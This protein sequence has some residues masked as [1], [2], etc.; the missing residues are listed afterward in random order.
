MTLALD[1]LTA[2]FSLS[3]L[4]ATKGSASKRLVPDVHHRPIR[5]PEHRLGISAGRVEHV[6][7]AG[8]TGLAALLQRVST[9]QAL[10]HGI[11]IGSAPGEVFKLV[12]AEQF[13]GTPGTIAR[14]KACIQYP[15]GPH[16]L[17]LDRD[18]EPEAA[19]L[20]NAEE[21]MRCM[22]GVLPAFAEVGWLATSSTSSAIREKQSGDWLTPP[23]GWHI[24]L[25]ATGDVARFGDLLKVRL[26]LTG[27]G[28]CKLAT[29][30]TQTGVCAILERALVDLMVFSPERLDYVAG[31]L[32]DKRAPFYQDR[33]A[34][35]LHAG[36]V[37]DLDAFPDV[38]DEERAQYA[39]LVAEAKEPLAPERRAR[40]RT[41]ITTA[42]PTLPETEVEQEITARLTHA[43]RGELAP[44]HTVYFVN[45]VSITAAAL[46]GP[47]GKKLDGKRLADPQEPTYRQGED[48]VFHWRRGDW[49]MVSWAHGIQITYQLAQLAPE[50]PSSDDGDMDDL[51]ARVGDTE[52]LDGLARGAREHDT[53]GLT[54]PYRATPHGLVWEKLTKDGP[55]DVL[56]TNFTATIT[57]DILEDDGAETRHRYALTVQHKGQS[58]GVEILAT[59]LAGMNWV[60][61]HL[62][63]TAI[64]M[65]GMT[66]KDHARAAIQ[67]LSQQITQH[68]VYTH[69]GWRKVGEDWC[70]LHAGGAIGAQGP[71][72]EVTVRPGEALAW[73]H[74]PTPPDGEAAR[75]AIRASFR[76]LDVAEDTVTMPGYAAVWRAVLGH[77][78]FGVHLAGATGQ[79][80]TELAA[81]LQQHW[82]GGM[83]ARRLPAS[84]SSTGNALEGLAFQAKDAMLVVD[85]FCPT[86]AKADI[87]RYHR[88][89]DRLMRAQGNHSG[90]QRMRQD[91]TLRPVKPPRGLIL[92]TGEDIP[93]GQSLRARLL[94][95]DVAPGTV[96]WQTLTACQGAATDGLYAQALAGFVRWLAPRYGE[97]V[98]DVA[99]ELR[100]LRQ[101]VLHDGHRRTPD[102]IANLALGM[103]YVLAYAHDCGAFT[104][105][106]CHT[107]WRRIW[108]ALGDVAAAQQEHQVGEEPASRFLALLAGAIAA[109]HAHVADA[110]TLYAPTQDAEY[111]GWREKVV[112]TGL[113]VREERQPCGACVGWVHETRLYL[114]PEAAFHTVQ[115]FAEGQQAPLPITQRI[116]WKRLREQ[117]LLVTQPSQQQN[118]VA[119]DIGPDKK[120]KRVLDLSVTLFSP[121]N[122]MNSMD[123]MHSAHAQQ[124]NVEVPYCFPAW[125]DPEQYA[126]AAKNS[127]PAHAASTRSVS[128]EKHTVLSPHSHTDLQEETVGSNNSQ[129]FEKSATHTVHTDHTVFPHRTDALVRRY[130]SMP[131]NGTHATAADES[132]EGVI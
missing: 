53:H 32:I 81:L 44:A 100:A 14:T 55:T 40:V 75:T 64:V 106:E 91:S 83:D 30:N 52:D 38:T 95:L 10:V 116:L 77:V 128:L 5:D 78:D 8:L 22:T 71:V 27:Y 61:E 46:S 24:Y 130:P 84:W 90:R 107:Y 13:T 49:R 76:V 122:S 28:F 34:P 58:H 119:R 60:A 3:L 54:M 127:M 25:L 74:L 79:G 104:V 88:E 93:H 48:A 89:A 131:A 114:E 101:H 47:E 67:L 98:A 23:D 123:S 121:E 56:L 115:R 70:Y 110:K 102:I 118:T 87:A 39:T 69:L 72:A 19:P 113:N 59:Q 129:P 41:H 6:Q 73:Y 99:V 35:E 42:T 92:S 7:V 124:N 11:P 9:K 45:G 65:P 80:K 126:H 37:L 43:E 26:W 96:Q 15:P 108:Q 111:W 103:Q 16:L 109:G 66:L 36:C 86:G 63:A 132:D 31:A 21:L 33:P 4:T 97:I 120:S 12:V 2:P 62:G 85:D 51:L 105:E 112:G 125:Y 18:P 94:I 20:A 68:R 17:M 82:G 50:P 57:A 29:Q 117:G 1:A